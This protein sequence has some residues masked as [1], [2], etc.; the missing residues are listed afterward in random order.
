MSRLLP[1]L[2]HQVSPQASLEG[3]IVVLPTGACEAHGPHLPLDTDVRIAV[4]MAERAAAQ[5]APYADREAVILAGKHYAA[6]AA[7]FK[8]K[9]LPLAGLGIGQQLAKLSTL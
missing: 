9:T 6:A 1:Q 8:N 7:A 4:G 5:L 3:A 2:A